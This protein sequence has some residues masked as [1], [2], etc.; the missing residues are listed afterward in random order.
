MIALAVK[1]REVAVSATTMWC[2]S[3]VR[4]SRWTVFG[5][6]RNPAEFLLAPVTEAA[7]KRLRFIRGRGWEGEGRVR[8][9]EEEGKA[10]L[11]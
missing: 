5:R 4:C 3:W 1:L 9:D 7:M 6:K 8:P 10:M 2:S 11:E